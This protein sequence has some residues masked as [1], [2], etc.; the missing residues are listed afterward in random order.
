[1]WMVSAN[2]APIRGWACSWTVVCT[3]TRKIAPL[4]PVRCY[5]INNFYFNVGITIC[6][7]ELS[8][9]R[10]LCSLQCCFNIGYQF[11]I[12]WSVSRKMSES[13]LA[14]FDRPRRGRP[15]SSSAFSVVNSIRRPT[16]SKYSHYISL[17]KGTNTQNIKM[18]HLNP[19]R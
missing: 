12:T 18:L 8:G 2:C 4:L 19:S 10:P 7:N 6:S 13:G 1:M 9:Y 3:N 16:S 5:M 17:V 15:L 14:P 11:T